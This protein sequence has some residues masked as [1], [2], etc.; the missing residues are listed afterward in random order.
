MS[1]GKGPIACELHDMT[2]PLTGM[3]IPREP[4]I[5]RPIRYT[6][7][8]MGVG[9]GYKSLGRKKNEIGIDNSSNPMR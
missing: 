5:G 6:R 3:S 8:Y 1:I 9:L 7:V 2:E 4:A